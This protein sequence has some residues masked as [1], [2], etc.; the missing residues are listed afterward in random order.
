MLG[1]QST[2][3]LTNNDLRELESILRQRDDVTFLSAEPNDGL[4]KLL[5][6]DTLVVSRPGEDDLD[7]YLA[8]ASGPAYLGMERTSEVKTHIDVQKSELVALERPYCAGDVM[9]WGRIY[10]TPT[11]F[12]DGSYHEKSP[13]FVKWAERVVAAIRRSLTYDKKLLSYVGKDAA[14]GIAA[15]VLRVIS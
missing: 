7:C 6:L 15:G 1:R 4:D 13:A 2:I 14:A 8:Q 12:E 5:P 3:L 10:Y 9:R 11:Y